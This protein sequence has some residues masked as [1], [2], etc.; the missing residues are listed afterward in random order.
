MRRPLALF[1][2]LLLLGSSPVSAVFL[3]APVDCGR[4]AKD[5]K[6]D[7]A[8][9]LEAFV[10]G[11][12]NGLSLGHGEEFWNAGHA[13]ISRDAVFL[14]LDKYCDMNPLNYLSDGVDELFNQRAETPGLN[15]GESR[16]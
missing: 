1:L 11:Y 8:D 10:I 9:I 3:Q 4:W 13:P 15:E 2:A 16:K 6:L 5:R 14:W 12:L 7:K